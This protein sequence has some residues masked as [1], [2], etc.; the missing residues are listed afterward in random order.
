MNYNP[1][2]KLYIRNKHLIDL[3]F[4][5]F[6]NLHLGECNTS[7]KNINLFQLYLTYIWVFLIDM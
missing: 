7:T 1:F 4:L 6:Q 5:T 2:L 3:A